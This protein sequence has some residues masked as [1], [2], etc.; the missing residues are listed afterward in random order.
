MNK[1]RGFTL[2]ELIVTVA[3]AAILLA[4]GV[5]SFQE[6]MRKNR[7]AAHMNEMI[8]ALNLARGEAA[9]RGQRVS[10]CPST[11]GTSCTGGT[12]WNNGWIVFTDTS[13]DDNTVTVGTVLRVGEALTGA[14]TFTGPTNFRYRFTGDAIAAGEF[15]YTLNAIT[16]RVCV[17]MVGRPSVEKVANSCP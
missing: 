12:D 3:I 15:V 9:K 11:D 13:A 6:T 5:P 4:V 7:T 14:P 2:A 17:S 1:Q 16:Q 10:L 8:T